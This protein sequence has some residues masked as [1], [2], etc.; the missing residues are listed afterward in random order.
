[1]CATPPV[2]AEALIAGILC[3][4]DWDDLMATIRDNRG[5]VMTEWQRLFGPRDF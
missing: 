1:V 3:F 2:A 4:D 5:V